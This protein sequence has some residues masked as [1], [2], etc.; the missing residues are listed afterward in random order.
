[1][2]QHHKANALSAGACPINNIAIEFKT[3]QNFVMILFITYEADPNKILHMS[4]W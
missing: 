3:R 4:L 1:M 2:T